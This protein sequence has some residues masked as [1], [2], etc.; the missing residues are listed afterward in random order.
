M[1]S[2]LGMYCHDMVVKED[3]P[4]PHILPPPLRAIRGKPKIFQLLFRE[5]D[6]KNKMTFTVN[7][8]FEP[9]KPNNP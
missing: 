8:V 4:S 2:L 6:I 5:H 1:R 7:K 3:Y 9:K